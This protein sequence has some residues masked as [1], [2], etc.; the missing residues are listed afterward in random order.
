MNADGHTV[1]RLEPA[2]FKPEEGPQAAG[3]LVKEEMARFR[4]LMGRDG[5]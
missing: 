4:K 5:E 2:A 3:E 1:T